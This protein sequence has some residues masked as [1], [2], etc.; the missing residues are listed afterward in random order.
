LEKWLGNE[1]ALVGVL[2]VVAACLS[3]LSRYTQ[4]F[5]AIGRNLVVLIVDLVVVVSAASGQ[6]ELAAV[7]VF[8][9]GHMVGRR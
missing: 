1:L 6:C 8:S 9:S 2:R 4:E 3:W 5:Q 7:S